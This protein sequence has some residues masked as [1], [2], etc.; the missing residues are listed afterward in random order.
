MSA[1]AVTAIDKTELGTRAIFFLRR[2]AA[3]T[4]DWFVIGIP[5]ALMV[6]GSMIVSL[7]L[8][9]GTLLAAG[10]TEGLAAEAG[11]GLLIGLVLFLVG[12]LVVVLSP[13]LYFRWAARREGER[14]GQT[15]GRQLLGLRVVRS[16]SAKPIRGRTLLLREVAMVVWLIPVAIVVGLV[17]A[18]TG[19]RSAHR[20]LPRPRS[21]DSSPGTRRVVAC[22]MTA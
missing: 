6:A 21:S 14:A 12:S 16:A 18:F 9:T 7:V 8:G 22:L 3:W 2:F 1:S 10:S 11:I 15:L 5:I 4:A 17:A 19:S 20:T 13:L